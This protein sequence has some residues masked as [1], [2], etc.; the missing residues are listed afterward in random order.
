MIQNKDKFLEHIARRLGRPRITEG[1]KRPKWTIT[2]QYDVHKDLSTDD[3]IDVLEKRCRD[4][5]TD[6]YRTTM[7]TLPKTLQK[8]LENYRVKSLIYPQDE[9][10]DTYGLRDFYDALKE[11]S[12][13]C[14][15]WDETKKEENIRFAEQADVGIAF[16]EI[17]LAESATVTLFHDTNHGRALSLLPHSFVVIIPKS[18]IVPRLT[19]ATKQIHEAHILGDQLPSCVSFV[20]GPSNSA[21][22]EMNLIVGVHGPVQAAYIVVDDA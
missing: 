6:F 17:T 7:N 10:N 13:E 14:F 21:D 11:M 5:H 22:I 18:T 2:P 3:L 4:I 12:V 8:V 19:Q 1:V 9:R 15:M 16:S 20:S